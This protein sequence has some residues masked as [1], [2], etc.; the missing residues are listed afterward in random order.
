[1]KLTSS[2]IDV[3]SGFLETSDVWKKKSRSNWQSNDS[4][5]KCQ[6]SQSFVFDLHLFLFLNLYLFLDYQM[7][8]KHFRPVPKGQG[9]PKWSIIHVPETWKSI[10]IIKKLGLKEKWNRRCIIAQ[11]DWVESSLKLSWFHL[12]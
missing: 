5:L 7:L 11:C 1:M 9:F 6:I 12:K 2:M 3:S 4:V 10:H 8:M